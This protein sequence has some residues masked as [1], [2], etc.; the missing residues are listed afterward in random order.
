MA[1]GAG[2]RRSLRDC[3]PTDL[4]VE[5]DDDGRASSDCVGAEGENSI[6]K[7]VG[8]LHITYYVLFLGT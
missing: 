2:Y 6:L 5:N 4:G 1:G 3:R 7:S 8:T